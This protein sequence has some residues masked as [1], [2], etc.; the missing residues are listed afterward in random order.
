MSD[1]PFPMVDTGRIERGG[2]TLEERTIERVFSLAS[3]HVDGHTLLYEQPD[4][5]RRVRETAEDGDLPWRFF[6]A[7]RLVFDPPLAGIG[8]MAVLP[9][10]LSSARREFVADLEERGFDG[11]DRGTT[12]HGRTDSGDRI[13]LTKYTARFET[14]DLDA[15]IEA[16]FGVW[17]R[18]DEFR[19]AGGAYPVSG[20]PVDLDPGGYR[21]ELLDLLRSV[22]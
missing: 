3:V 15:E 20:L 8:P 22:E 10:V 5:R 14:A 18:R 12:Q 4:L 9:V 13:R 1:D 17:V 2:W 21:E 11:I 7:T 19:A 6:F 16:W